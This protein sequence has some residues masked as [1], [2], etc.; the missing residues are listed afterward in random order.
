MSNPALLVGYDRKCVTPAPGTYLGG[1]GNGKDRQTIGK[2]FEDDDLFI[3]AIAMTDPRGET[4]LL[5]TVDVVRIPR[6]GYDDMIDRLTAATGVPADHILMSATHSHSS[7]DFVDGADYI[8]T[9]KALF[10]AQGE[11]AAVAALADRKPAQAFGTVR[12]VK[13]L[14]WVRR[15]MK[16]GKF[17]GTNTLGDAHESA[18]DN[19]LQL[20][21][22]VREGGEDV[23][24]CNWGAHSDHSKC[25]GGPEGSPTF[26]RGCSADYNYALRKTVE[27]ETGAKFAFFQAAAGNLNPISKIESEFYR[28]RGRMERDDV[29]RPI[30]YGRELAGE[31]TEALKGSMMPLS[32][33]KA[34]G[35]YHELPA[36]RPTGP[37]VGSPEYNRAYALSVVAFAQRTLEVPTKESREGAAFVAQ[38][39]ELGDDASVDRL[40]ADETAEKHDF[41]VIAKT[42]RDGGR[43]PYTSDSSRTAGFALTKFY[44]FISGLYSANGLVSRSENQDK[45]PVALPLHAISIGDIAFVG[46]PGEIFDTVGAAVKAASPF[47]MT[48]YLEMCGGSYGYFGTHLAWSHGGYEIGGASFA[49]GTVEAMGE[50]QL[51]ML[52]EMKEQ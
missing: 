36:K 26:H 8:E 52:K 13:D 31:V 23:I 21:R 10:L 11:A 27:A 6:R 20:L 40:A 50:E 3:T 12:E 29:I 15:Y 25:F 2:I 9:W 17:L 32:C 47:K 7:P 34:V 1:Y 48:F 39:Y 16:D 46:A 14:N 35:S 38:K 19:H 44:G 42:L 37:A 4:L 28:V 30:A 43:L 51:K 24:L 41:A 5:L 33:D 22:F 18:A 45:P 49:E